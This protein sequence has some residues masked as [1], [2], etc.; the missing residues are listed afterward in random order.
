MDDSWIS[1]YED[2]KERLKIGERHIL[3]MSKLEQQYFLMQTDVFREK[4]LYSVVSTEAVKE[5]EE[6]VK[7]L[8]LKVDE[9]KEEL[10]LEGV[11]FTRELRSFIEDPL[12]HLKKKIFVYTFDLFA[13]NLTL[14]EFI[15]KASAAIRTSLRTNMRTIYQTWVFL[16]L[17]E[18]L[19]KE[20]RI[21]YPE[22]GYLYLERNA[23]Q[24][25][26]IIP[27]NCIVETRS[28]GRL[29][30]FIEAP[31][32]IAWEDSGDLK[33]IWKLYVCLRPDFMVY[34]GS[35]MNILDLDKMPP[36]KK[37]DVI[38]ECKELKD[39][40]KR[41]RDLR[42]WWAKA[43]S[44]EE[45]R[46]LWLKGLLEGLG[47]A[48]GLKKIVDETKSETRK[49]WRVK[50][51]RLVQLYK[52]FYNPDEMILVTRTKVPPNIKSEIEEM[53]LIVFENIGFSSEKL[54][55]VS[56]LL[57]KYSKAEKEDF[58]AEVKKL[59]GIKASYTELS[60]ALLELVRRHKE[61]L[62]ELLAKQ[63]F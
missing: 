47:E 38:I 15:A 21:V 54:A 4:F 16:S 45:W 51:Y 62:V 14:E 5:A 40:Y 19:A 29:S 31:R 57:M 26:R 32:P 27:P 7:Y 1:I 25:I 63:T 13:G 56:E 43:M 20:G 35:V 42:G 30:F 58:F 41:S 59:T 36:V 8:L 37:P 52:N 60:K 46:F 34:G 9:V 28:G 3:K 2:L 18:Y 23:R 49:G 48:M 10:K 6:W 55:E 50:E 61:E 24:K 53:G 44:A 22:H 33:K 12:E 17:I 39:W 11:T